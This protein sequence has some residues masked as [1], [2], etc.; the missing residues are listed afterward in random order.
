MLVLAG[1]AGLGLLHHRDDLC[2]GLVAGDCAGPLA[3]DDRVD[4]LCLAQAAKAVDPE[5]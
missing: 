1:G 3:L 5:L 4:E 2:L